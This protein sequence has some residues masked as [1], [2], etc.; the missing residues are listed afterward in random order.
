LLS[1][2]AF[3]AGAAAL[4]CEIAAFEPHGGVHDCDGDARA[5][6]FAGAAALSG[7]PTAS[8]S[9]G[10]SAG[11]SSE[12]TTQGCFGSASASAS[13]S[14]SAAAAGGAGD[15]CETISIQHSRAGAAFTK[16]ASSAVRARIGAAI[17]SA[18]GA[19]PADERF[20]E[21]R[22]TAGVAGQA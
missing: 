10:R 13:L 2:P 4:S 18:D 17:G 11:R 6:G 14:H 9:P 5:A 15:A 3:A 20:A 22:L 1:L 19:R 12:R 8:A 7:A 16:S 21:T